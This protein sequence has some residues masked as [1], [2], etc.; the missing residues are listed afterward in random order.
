MH[1]SSTTGATALMAAAH[2]GHLST[3]RRLLRA[4]ARTD[5]KSSRGATAL[6]L[7][8]TRNAASMRDGC[9]DPLG[10]AVR[11]A[12]EHAHGTT[13]IHTSGFESTHDWWSFC[14]V[15]LKVCTSCLL[16]AT[17]FQP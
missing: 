11:A 8:S 9:D 12:I 7:A 17:F 1:G 13:D 16:L 15:P 10:K 2:N 14:T 3:A 5:L 6:Q 4:G